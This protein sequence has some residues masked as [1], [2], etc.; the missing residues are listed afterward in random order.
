M[1]GEGIILITFLVEKVNTSNTSIRES[2][3]E[4]IMKIASNESLY[5]VKASFKIVMTGVSGKSAKIKKE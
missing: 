4:L 2:I 5:P 3:K 1:E